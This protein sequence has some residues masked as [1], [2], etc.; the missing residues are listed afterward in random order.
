MKQIL[1]NSIV[2]L[3]LSTHAQQ[4][5]NY[6]VY[7]ID[8]Y[9]TAFFNTFFNIPEK[10]DDIYGKYFYEGLSYFIGDSTTERRGYYGG[11]YPRK[12]IDVKLKMKK[13]LKDNLNYVGCYFLH[14]K[15]FKYHYLLDSINEQPQSFIDSI[16]NLYKK[17][18]YKSSLDTNNRI[19]ILDH[20]SKTKRKTYYLKTS[21]TQC[22]IIFKFSR[23]DKKFLKQE[24]YILDDEKLRV[25]ENMLDLMQVRITDWQAYHLYKCE[26]QLPQE[27]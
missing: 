10:N 6:F 17:E 13:S 24:N 3:A 12:I 27:H 7:H 4:N 15:D 11:S 1:L 20:I 8:S 9:R 26:W 18:I 19:E 5:Q 16:N 23:K 2:F 22:E 14:V 25:V 21:K